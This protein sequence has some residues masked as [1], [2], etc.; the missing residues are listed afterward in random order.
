MV[1]AALLWSMAGVVTRHLDSAGSFEAT[2][3][4]SFFNA[5]ALVVLLGLLR[6]TVS[7][8]NATSPPARSTSTAASIS[9]CVARTV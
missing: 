5:L 2:F 6:E 9:V 1:V 3:W 7:V 4:R 8:G